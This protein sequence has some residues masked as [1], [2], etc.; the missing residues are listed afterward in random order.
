MSSYNDISSLIKEIKSYSNNLS[1]G[2]N[3]VFKSMILHYIFG[4]FETG[5]V[6]EHT[7]SVFSKILSD[8]FNSVKQF[9]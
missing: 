3:L 8:A 5:K 9:F 1:Y 2:E 4:A 6:E 7:T